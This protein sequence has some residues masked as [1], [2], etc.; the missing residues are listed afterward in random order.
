MTTLST[1][2]S[3]PQ[4]SPP[5]L[6]AKRMRRKKLNRP[7]VL[8]TAIAIVVSMVFILPALWILVGSLRPSG[9]IFSS[10]Y[11][12]SWD[13]LVPSSLS[14]D[15]YFGLLAS[16]FGRALLNSAIV[17]LASVVLGVAV[18]ALA[19]Y[20]LAVLRFPGRSFAFGF[21]VISF[22]VPFEAIAIPLSQQFS[23]WNLT[24]TMIGLIL[25]GV[26]NGLAIFNLR[27]YF[28]GIPD[29]LREAAKLDGASEPRTL[30]SVYLPNSGPALVNS[31]LLIFL[32]QWT[33]YLWP[34]LVV[35]DP[36]L[37]LAPVAL[38]KTFSEHTSDF[39]QNFAGAILLSLVPALLMFGLQ[40]FFGG[41]SMTSGEK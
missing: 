22:M 13:I 15:N 14:L 32:G 9:E 6:A 33:A 29:S 4:S 38:A 10:L 21:V 36:E 11:P 16:G 5:P 37:Q 8:A 7:P 2:V 35:S 31:A 41:L 30:W 18:V 40:R 26:G 1:K 20:A 17:C 23:D 28:L 27:Q 3:S 25:P 39:G 24:N 34:L 12:L 19:S